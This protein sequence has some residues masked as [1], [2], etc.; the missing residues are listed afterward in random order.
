MALLTPKLADGTRLRLDVSD[1]DRA[2]VAQLERGQK[3]TVTDRATGMRYRVLP[4][5]CPLPHCYCDAVAIPLG[6]ADGERAT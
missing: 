3:A 4:A 2:A 1:E 6:P 5:P